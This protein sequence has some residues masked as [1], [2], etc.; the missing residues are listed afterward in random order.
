RH[1]V[2]VLP[3]SGQGRARGGPRG[4]L[5]HPVR[6]DPQDHAAH[7]PPPRAAAPRPQSVLRD[8]AVLFAVVAEAR[9]RRSAGRRA[10][11]DHVVVHGTAEVVASAGVAGA[12][13][14]L[15]RRVRPAGQAMMAPA[16]PDTGKVPAGF[17][18]AIVYP[19]CGARRDEVRVGP[20]AGVDTAVIDLPN[21]YSMALTTDP[22]SLIP[23]L[24]LEESAWLT[25]HRAAADRAPAGCPAL[26]ALCDPT[27]PPGLSAG[28]F[29]AYWSYVPGCCEALGC[30][31]VGGHTGRFEGQ[32]STVVGG[33][34]MITVA[35]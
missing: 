23:S 35:R 4:P 11:H 5:R 16:F 1:D 34:M 18:E 15:S 29:E 2:R 31:I 27:V 26:S 33:G 30:A 28:A 6:H 10:L 14:R 13:R 12:G 24:G 9:H 17:L 21:G 25:R 8:G 3:G 7:D 19:R 32:H 20:A 22:C